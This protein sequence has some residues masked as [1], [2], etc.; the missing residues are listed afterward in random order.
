MLFVF[1][2]F[3]RLDNVLFNAIHNSNPRDGSVLKQRSDL[4]F[5]TVTIFM[6]TNANVQDWANFRVLT[7]PAS[8]SRSQIVTRQRLFSAYMYHSARFF[9]IKCD[10]TLSS[11]DGFQTRVR[12]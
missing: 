12:A 10:E 6:V 8:C 4:N 7:N 11:F 9:C 5:K 1:I 3:C 2:G